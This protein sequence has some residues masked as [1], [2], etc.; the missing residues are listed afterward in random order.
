MNI[1]K[2]DISLDILNQRSKN[3]FCDF[4]GIKFTEIGDNFIVAEM[5]L[6]QKH[7]QPLGIMNG[8][9][10]CAI[11]ETVGSTAANHVIDKNKQYCVGLEINTSHLRSV[12]NGSLIAKASPH[13]IGNNIHVWGIEIFND[14]K[15][16]SINKLTV[17]VRD[18]L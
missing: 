8:G 7:K 1:W 15:M 4:L 5:L 16:I 14:N 3:T 11:A 2:S 17:F 18:F 12:K 9:V 6:E 10:S 13:R